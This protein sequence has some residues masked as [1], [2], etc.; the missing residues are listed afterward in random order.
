MNFEKHFPNPAIF[1]G[2][3]ALVLCLMPCQRAT[4]ALTVL[5]LDPTDDGSISSNGTVV[6][7][8]YLMASGS[9][10]GVAVF[11]IIG[12]AGSIQSAV[13]EVNPY[14]LPIAPDGRLYGMAATEGS[15]VSAQYSGGGDLGEITFPADIRFGEGRQFDVTAFVKSLDSDFVAFR[16]ESEGTMVLSS[17]EFN[18]GKPAQLTL[19]L[20]PEPGSA[21]LGGL[22]AMLLLLRR[23]R[24]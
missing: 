2:A 9:L 4:A 11:P 21:M 20:I 12:L 8:A 16:I 5:T 23:D 6:R 24:R 1:G 18:Y 17:L 14:G 19:T 13:L 22:A 15:I 3:I 7:T 10:R